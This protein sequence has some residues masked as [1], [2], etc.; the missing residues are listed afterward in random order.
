MGKVDDTSKLRNFINFSRIGNKTKSS[1]EKDFVLT[2]FVG[3]CEA[4]ELDV[5]A[6]GWRCDELEPKATT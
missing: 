5:D 3:I 2:L 6:V 4:L 1:T